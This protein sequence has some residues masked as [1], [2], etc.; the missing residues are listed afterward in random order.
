MVECGSFFTLTKEKA[1]DLYDAV[2]KLKSVR[3]SQKGRS[4]EAK[5]STSSNGRATPQPVSER[6]LVIGTSFYI[7]VAFLEKRCFAAASFGNQENC[8]QVY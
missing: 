8:S 5:Q 7:A 3:I 1:S 4:T 2:T 6:L